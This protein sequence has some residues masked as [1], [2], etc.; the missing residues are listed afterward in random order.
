M[1]SHRYDRITRC[2][3]FAGIAAIV[4]ACGAGTPEV[5]NA[6]EP[7]GDDAS[8]QAT[9]TEKETDTT[10]DDD[11]STEHE[12]QAA[13]DDH[14]DAGEATKVSDHGDTRVVEVEMLE[15]AYEPSSIEVAAGEE[16][17]LRFVNEGQVEH[18]AMVGDVHMQEEFAASDDHGSHGDQ[19]GGH[20]G[21]VMAVTVPPGGSVD[22]PVEI[23]EPG[24]V[25]IGCHLPGH[26]EAGMQ[27][28]LEAT[29]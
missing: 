18:E 3:A 8:E 7:D 14:A 25:Y 15:F 5:S 19:G 1:R 12:D 9:A 2:V 29:A 27:A 20:H 10:T 21:D 26:Y 16:V 22:L 6:P 13:E 11:T 28:T 4:A 23:D 17:V 24:E